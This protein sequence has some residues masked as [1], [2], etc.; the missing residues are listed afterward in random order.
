LRITEIALYEL[1]LPLAEPYHL[2]R[3][4]LFEGFD[5]TFIRIGTDEGIEGWGEVC[6]WGSSYLPAFTGGVRAGAAELAPHLI[7]QDPRRP[8]V[9]M[10]LMDAALPGHLYVKALF[11][12]AIWDVLGKATGLPVCDLLGGREEGTAPVVSSL[13]N[14]SPEG[15]VERLESWRARGFKAHSLKLGN[16]GV[17]A[18]IARVEALAP[19]RR[20]D[21]VFLFDVNGGWTPWEA[22]RVMNAVA[23]YEAWFEQ[24]CPTY[25]QCLDVRRQT[26]QALSLDEV[27]VDVTDV[28][29]ALADKACDVVNLKLARVGGLTRARW[30]RDLCIASGLPMLVMCMAG[31]VVNDTAVAHFAQ[32]IPR[33]LCIGTWSCQDM[34]TVDAAPGR[35]ARN[36]DGYMVPPDLPGMGVEPDLDRLGSPIARFTEAS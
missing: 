11:D 17:D 12:Y 19:Q 34:L 30:I 26:R 27:I 32:S 2:S 6:P 10:R 22:L 24:P 14:D 4:R 9:L 29:R 7:G 3:G 28:S 18:D 21:E 5:S 33:K 25:D 16:G 20:E 35:G 1:E 23:D 13:Q 15:M 31:T 36:V 8:E